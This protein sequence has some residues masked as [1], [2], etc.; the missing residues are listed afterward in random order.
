MKNTLV[1]LVIGLVI[2]VGGYFAL[3]LIEKIGSIDKTTLPAY[4]VYFESNANPHKDLTLALKEAKKEK[5]KILLIVGGDWCKWCGILD[6]FLEKNKDIEKS[7]YT[8]YK[9]VRVYY[10]NG[11]NKDSKSLLSQFPPVKETPH[12]FVLDENAKLL[13]SQKTAVLEKGYGY[14]KD[15]FKR[16]LDKHK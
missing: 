11:M 12:F 10:G 7:L 14:H 4:S 5:K 15:K 2:A 13:H 9:V 3:P 6:D 1:G 8:D 16:F